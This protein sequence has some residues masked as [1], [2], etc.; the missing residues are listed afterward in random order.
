M[1]DQGLQIVILESEHFRNARRFVWGEVRPY[2]LALSLGKRAYFSHSTAMFLRALTDQ[3]PK[4]I[5]VNEEQTP[6]NFG[7]S[8]LTQ[9][10]IDRAFA[11]KQRTSRAIYLWNDIRVL[12]VSGKWTERLETGQVTAP[13]GTIADATKIERTLI[14]IAVRPDYAGGP[15]Q[16]LAAYAMARE[17]VSV[18]VIIA[19]LKKLNYAY[20][21]HQVIGFYMTRAGFSEKQTEPLKRLG[22]HF[23]FYLTYGIKERDYDSEWGLFFPKGF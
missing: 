10:G 12:L 19:T 15:Q 9:P 4:T 1:K 16:V 23:D 13:D 20:P 22:S 6:K 2:E 5:Y 14:D 21:Y 7:G 17:R 3:I 8:Q 18:S 11:G